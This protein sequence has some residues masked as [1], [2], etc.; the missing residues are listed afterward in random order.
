M[1]IK[2][3]IALLKVGI[4]NVM[5]DDLDY[6]DEPADI[7]QEALTVLEALQPNWLPYPKNKPEKFGKHFVCLQDETIHIMEWHGIMGWASPYNDITDFAE[8]SLPEGPDHDKH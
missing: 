7:M 1:D 3:I 5:T 4:D 8:F 2:T 6:A